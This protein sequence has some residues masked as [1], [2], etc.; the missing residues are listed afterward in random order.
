[1]HLKFKFNDLALFH[2]IV[3]GTS[4]IQLPEY[5]I[6]CPTGYINPDTSGVYFQRNTRNTSCFDHLMFKCRIVPKIDAFRDDFYYRT[7]CLWNTLPLDLREIK[8]RECFKIKL[9]EYLW[10]IADAELGT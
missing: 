6:S 5:Y 1:M 2:S 4:T 3:F 8:S 10:I 9:K 7:V